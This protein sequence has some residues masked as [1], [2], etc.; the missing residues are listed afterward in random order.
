MAL[1]LGLPVPH[2]ETSGRVGDPPNLTF[3]VAVSVLICPVVPFQTVRLRVVAFPAGLPLVALSQAF[4]GL[5]TLSQVVSYRCCWLLG[6]VV[7]PSTSTW[8]VFVSATI[9]PAGLSPAAYGLVTVGVF[10]LLPCLLTVSQV[11]CL[12]H[13]LVT[14]SQVFCLLAS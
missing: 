6:S 5:V 12:P 8:S 14:R 11:F 1:S 10:C 4:D 9:R 13:C 3:P 2:S 7:D